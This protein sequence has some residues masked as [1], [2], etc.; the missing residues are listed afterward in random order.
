[1]HIEI[2]KKHIA[3]DISSAHNDLLSG[4]ISDFHLNSNH[5]FSIVASPLATKKGPEDFL[6]LELLTNK[7]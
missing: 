6:D 4:K 5:S 3:T 2:T 7:Y 1:M